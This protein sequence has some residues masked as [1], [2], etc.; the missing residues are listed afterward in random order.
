MDGSG[1]DRLLPPSEEAGT[2]FVSLRYSVL[3]DV[4]LKLIDLLVFLRLLR[5]ADWD[6]GKCWPGLR[7]LANTGHPLG[8]ATVQ[9]AIA[10][11]RTL[12]YLTRESRGAG[13]SH[14]YT[15]LDGHSRVYRQRY[16]PIHPS[17]G[18]R[19][20]RNR[21]V[22]ATER[23]DLHEPSSRTKKNASRSNLE[24]QAMYWHKYLR[25]NGKPP[26]SAR[27]LAAW[28]DQITDGGT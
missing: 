20:G 11:L 4:R 23:N 18:V 7:K 15:M 14:G 10:R 24:L 21:G 12:G 8:L 9:R 13:Q 16:T 6:T 5:Y 25:A 27:E 19:Q 26:E 1:P 2:L 3:E 28:A 22:P 17:I